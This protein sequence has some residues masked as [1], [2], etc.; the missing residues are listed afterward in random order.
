MNDRTDWQKIMK[1]SWSMLLLVVLAALRAHAAG[2]AEGNVTISDY[3]RYAINVTQLPPSHQEEMKR[4]AK[5]LVGALI[6]GKDVTVIVIGHADFDAQGR[7]FEDKVSDERALGAASALNHFVDQEAALTMLSDELKNR[8]YIA[9]VG[10]GTLHPVVL[11]P[12]NEED[13]KANRRVEIQWEVQDHPPAPPFRFDDCVRVL[14]GQSPPGPT[15]RM[16]CVCQKL[17]AG[18]NVKSYYYRYEAHNIIPGAAGLPHLTDD[19]WEAAR[20]ALFGYFR[21]DISSINRV[22]GLSDA[23]KAE[24]LKALDLQVGTDIYNWSTKIVAEGA[25]G[26]L[27]QAVLSDIKDRMAD[28]NHTYSCYAG[29][30]HRDR[31]K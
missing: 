29:Y 2:N 16:T 6:A 27:E 30:S 18:S 19:Q 7:A 31:D 14:A 3:P 23:Q 8:L 1:I 26:N 21:H 15:R 28:P 13:R 22:A 9:S 10:V 25:M 12:Q 20:K 11:R 24:A 4:V 5:A 17:Q